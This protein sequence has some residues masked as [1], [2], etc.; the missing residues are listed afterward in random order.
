VTAPVPATCPLPALGRARCGHRYAGHR[1]RW[2]PLRWASTEPG[3]GASR[4][5]GGC[6]CSPCSSAPMA[7]VCEQ[8]RC[9]GQARPSLPIAPVVAHEHRAQKKTGVPLVKTRRLET[10]H[11]GLDSQ[12]RQIAR[13]SSLK[14]ATGQNRNRRLVPDYK[15]HAMPSVGGAITIYIC[16]LL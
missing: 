12:S 11:G 2:A 13:S 5:R 7:W 9:S 4:T 10:D 6:V 14:R 1:L 8:K 3:T 16:L 15:A